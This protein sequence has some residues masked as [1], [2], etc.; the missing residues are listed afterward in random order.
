MEQK[1]F[2]LITIDTEG[3]DLW[4]RSREITTENARDMPRFQ[5]LCEI[6]GLRP[7]YLVSYEMISDPAFKEFAKDILKRNKA[8]IG[9]HLHAWNTPPI[10]PLTAD[11][12][13][14]HPYMIE[15]PEEIM[16]KKVDTITSALENTFGVRPVSHLNF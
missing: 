9:M 7:V 14:F 16:R 4:S 13:K 6:Y 2:F 8:E 15:Y 10:I 1:P 12:F 11:D 5:S 3:D